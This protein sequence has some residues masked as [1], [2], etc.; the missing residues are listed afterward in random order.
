M[1]SLAGACGE[2]RQ[3]P[4]ILGNCSFCPILS[5]SPLYPCPPLSWK[6]EPYAVGPIVLSSSVTNVVIGKSVGELTPWKQTVT[7]PH[8]VFIHVSSTQTELCGEGGILVEFS[9]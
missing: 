4:L 7:Q 6:S 1:V 5:V 8:V 2:K 9:I 3:C